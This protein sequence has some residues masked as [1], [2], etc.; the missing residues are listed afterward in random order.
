[1]CSRHF[2]PF[3]VKMHT[4]HFTFCMIVKELGSFQSWRTQFNQGNPGRSLGSLSSV[5]YVCCWAWKQ[6]YVPGQL[7]LLS[8]PFL[9]TTSD[10]EA[11]N[12]SECSWYYS[13]VYTECTLEPHGWVPNH[14]S[15]LYWKPRAGALH[16]GLGGED[17][18]LSASICF[19]ALPFENLVVLKRFCFQSTLHS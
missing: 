16:E 13:Q 4:H 17:W 8:S 6:M 3:P 2:C 5:K 1:M 11:K 18:M 15:A 7:G 10:C 14:M 12:K 19:S 9:A